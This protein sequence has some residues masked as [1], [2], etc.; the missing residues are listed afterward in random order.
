MFAGGLGSLAAAASP[1][2][3]KPSH[4]VFAHYM[5]CFATYG[6]S[7]AGYQREMREA[8]AAGLDGFALNLGAYD[9]SNQP[10]YN[11][12]VELL[13]RAAE[14]LGTNFKLFFSIDCIGNREVIKH[15]ISTHANRPNTFRHQGRVVVSTYADNGPDWRGILDELRA[16]GVDVF[17]MPYFLSNPDR[18]LPDYHNALGILNTYSNVLDG[19]FLFA[20]AG[21]PAQLAQ[22]NSNYNRAFHEAGKP[23]MASVAPHYWGLSQESVGRRYY[24][25]DGGEGLALQWNSVIRN[26]PDWVEICT[27]NDFNESTYI[28]PADDPGRSNGELIQP[29]RYSHAGYLELSK[30][31]IA[32]FKSGAQPPIDRDELYYFYRTHPQDLKALNQS[33]VRVGWREGDVRDLIYTTLFLTSPAELEISSGGRLATNSLPAGLQNVRTPFLPGPQTFTLRRDG[34]TVLT[35]AGPSILSA[36]R[37]YDFFPASGF[38]RSQTPGA[39]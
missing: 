31:Y 26:Q 4:E 7:I 38:A 2:P 36:I 21:L 23:F 8:Q 29:R 39:N 35:A 27:W 19:F 34:Q 13:F 11:R 17:F 15:L 1:A 6:E 18:E 5:V 3:L 33:E 20:A 30:H 12:R 24:E 25:F 14:A 22:C 9:D 32:W 10:Y 16:G 28:C 37:V